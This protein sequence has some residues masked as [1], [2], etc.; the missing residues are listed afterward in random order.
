MPNIES[1][2]QYLTTRIA[3]QDLDSSINY[4]TQSYGE[5]IFQKMLN[6]LLSKTFQP[7]EASDYWRCA[8]QS[9][10]ADNSTMNWRAIMFDHL[11]CRTDLLRNPRIIDAEELQLLQHNAITDGLTCL[12]N[13]SHFKHRLA[14]TIID[15]EVRPDSSFSLIILDLDHFKQFNDRCGHL[16]GDHALAKI[17]KLI[18][19][20][21]PSNA[22]AARYGGEEFA[23][24]L[25]DTDLPTAIT[26]AEK[27]RAAVEQASFD[28]EDRLDKGKLTISGGVACYPE[29][30][31][32]TVSLI[33]HADSN[34]YAAKVSRNCICPTPTNSRGIIR[35]AFRSIVE[36]CDSHS[37]KVIN[38]L[39]S[40]ISSTGL[41]LKCS[42][43][44]E[45]GST[46]QLRFPFPF[47]PSDHL[48]SGEVRHVRT[49]NERGSYMVGIQ[50]VQPQTDFIEL[51]LP[52]EICV[53]SH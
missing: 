28:G 1:F 36:V 9:F 47:W 16:R 4:L 3:N 30:G 25:P 15:H 5:N 13:Q 33:A 41:L 12:F 27:I 7:Q 26:L 51:V 6:S 11:F 29:A 38:S 19:S 17:G 39:S 21:I 43:P 45:I 35:H 52:R 37:G 20:Q 42:V 18:S 31:K 53:T 48:T 32:T 49:Q 34:L 2:E 24:I 8:M 22:L 50:F 46:M 44:C 14:T 23:V 10:L 40:D